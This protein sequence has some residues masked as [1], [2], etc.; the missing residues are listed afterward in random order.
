MDEWPGETGKKLL[1]RVA[2]YRAW[3]IGTAS[4]VVGYRDVSCNT[5]TTMQEAMEQT[6]LMYTHLNHI[7]G[8]V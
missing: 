5:Y 2:E 1:T 4:E 6:N 7:M 8:Q 3:H